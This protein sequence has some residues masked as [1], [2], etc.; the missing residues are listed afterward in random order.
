MIT[1]ISNSALVEKCREFIVAD[2]VLEGLDPAIKNALISSNREISNLG[3]YQPLAWLRQHYDELFTRTYA[4]ISAITQANPGI[5]TA[6]SLD[7]DISDNHGF[8]TGD[9]VWIQGI[10]G[11]ERL[12]NRLFLFTSVS[13]TTFSLTQLDGKNAIN[14]TDY[15]E[16]SSGGYVYHAGIKL[17]ASTIEPSTGAE[18]YRWKIKRVWDVTADG[19]PAHPVSQ[20][21][22]TGDPDL[23]AP[24]ASP[25][26]WRYWRSALTDLTSYD[27]YVI[28]VPPVAMRYA[29]G[30]NIERGYPDLSDW[31]GSIY[32]PQPPEIHDYI[33][34]RALANMVTNAERQRR[35]SETGR[36]MGQIEVLYAHHWKQQVEDDE[37]EIR[38][39][40]KEMLGDQP[41][42]KG[43]SA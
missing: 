28:F 22:S 6:E 42:S 25:V 8:Q 24:V 3:G 27:H 32:P 10:A 11:M 14:T 21:K 2:P 33:W 4:A 23:R 17:P 15:E 19:L 40:S 13:D 39:L 36:L 43:W 30:V 35:E 18:A 7:T 31:S 26:H 9:I 38:R 34:H 41:S 1:K 16:Y 37:L 12:N 29:I 20:E 5:F